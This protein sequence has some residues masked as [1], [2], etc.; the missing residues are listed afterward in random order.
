MAF[1]TFAGATPESDE[2]LSFRREIRVKRLFAP[3]AAEADLRVGGS[4]GYD[5]VAARAPRNLLP[6]QPPEDPVSYPQ[7]EFEMRPQ[8]DLETG[9]RHS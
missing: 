7:T 4:Q 8:T 6:A 1:R 5:S 2:S 9:L 3:L